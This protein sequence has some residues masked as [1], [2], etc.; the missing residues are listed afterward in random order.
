MPDHWFV[1]TTAFTVILHIVIYKLYIET[2]YWNLVSLCA[3]LV[4]FLLYYLMLIGFST[5]GISIVFQPQLNH[6]LFRMWSSGLFWILIAVLPFFALMPDLTI[7]LFQRVI[8]KNPAD[9]VMLH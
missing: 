4:S 1:T 5:N 8:F 9:A 2:V 6:E 7:T 3:V